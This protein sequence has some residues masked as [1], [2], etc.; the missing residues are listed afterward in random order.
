MKFTEEINKLFEAKSPQY[1]LVYVDTVD[2]NVEKLVK[3]LKSFGVYVGSVSAETGQDDSGT[4]ILYI[5]NRKL[6]IKK[7]KEIYVKEF[8]YNPWET[9]DAKSIASDSITDRD[10]KILKPL[11]SKLRK[12]SG[13]DDDI[14]DKIVVYLDKRWGGNA[15]DVMSYDFDPY[16]DTWSEF[17]KFLSNRIKGV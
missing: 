8:D 14:F 6:G 12:G 4:D 17:L 5:S 7:L 16:E 15:S 13:D 10:I 3:A 2:E 9:V 1:K 11:V